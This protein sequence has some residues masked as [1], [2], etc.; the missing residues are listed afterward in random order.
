[1]KNL[2]NRQLEKAK[3]PVYSYV[4]AWECP[5]N[6]GITPFHCSELA[7]C[8]HALSVPQVRTPTGGGP[9]ALAL[10]D[11]VS[12]GWINFARTGGPA[13]PPGRFGRQFTRCASPA[14]SPPRLPGSSPF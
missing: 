13:I 2:L 1:V 11:K 14:G 7:F 4:F 12:H 10:Q 3:T 5:V 9:V 8:F 6:G